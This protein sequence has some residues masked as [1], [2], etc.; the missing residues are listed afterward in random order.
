MIQLRID[1][2]ND[3]LKYLARQLSQKE[4]T[5]ASVRSINVALRKA[6]VHYKREIVKQYNLKYGDLE[7]MG[8][9]PKDTKGSIV[10]S[11]NATY[12]NVV[13][14]I[15][16]LKR[17]ISLSRFNPIFEGDHQISGKKLFINP[18]TG[19]KSYRKHTISHKLK[20]VT[21]E[22]NR[23]QKKQIP[24]AFMHPNGKPSLSK[25]VFAR[26]SYKD[27]SLGKSP[28]RMPIS[29]IK[30]TSPM[31]MLVNSKVKQQIQAKTPGDI[32]KEFKRQAE[33]LLSKRK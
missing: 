25:L 5:K 15:G 11:N 30:T 19:R 1:T 21:V 2:K 33:L 12:S 27:G 17:P 6:K 18:E 16:G 7:N 20:G 23:G 10:R 9:D 13:G 3:G 26:G 14:T 31:A 32:R 8:T 4:L 28:K 22:I 24:Y 29:V